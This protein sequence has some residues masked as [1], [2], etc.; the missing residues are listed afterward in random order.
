[1]RL[2]VRDI[3]LLG[4]GT[5][6]FLFSFGVFTVL[7]EL[8]FRLAQFRLKAPLPVGQ[9][10]KQG[11][12]ALPLLQQFFPGG[13]GVFLL[14]VHAA[15]QL[16]NFLVMFRYFLLLVRHALPVGGI[17]GLLLL[18]PFLIKISLLEFFHGFFRR[19]RGVLGFIQLFPGLA[20]GF[21]Q[22]H[23]MLFHGR[24]PGGQFP[25]FRGDAVLIV[26]DGKSGG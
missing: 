7:G 24:F 3:I 1:M 17:Q 6:K 12:Q 22:R 13:F 8:P 5:G 14:P 19:M 10:G 20:D 18:L 15:A 2:K 4:G 9:L 25:A 21:F 11:F 16:V 26:P 23:G